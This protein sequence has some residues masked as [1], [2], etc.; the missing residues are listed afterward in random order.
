MVWKENRRVKPQDIAV[1]L[2]FHRCETG[3]RGYRVKFQV[4]Q[5]KNGWPFIDDNK[6]E[7]SIAYNNKELQRR[8]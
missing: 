2:P 7:K 6:Q 8:N 1:F 3:K 4:S 5:I